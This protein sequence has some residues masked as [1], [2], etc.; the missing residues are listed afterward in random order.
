MAIEKIKRH[1]SPG[2]DQIPT[3][4][5]ITE[6]EKFASRSINIFILLGIKRN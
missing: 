3:E 5:I 2:S 1:K 6:V 4:L